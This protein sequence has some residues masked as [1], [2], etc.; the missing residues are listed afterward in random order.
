MF[1]MLI[2]K[3]SVFITYDTDDDIPSV[4]RYT[5]LS[6]IFRFIVPVLIIYK[7]IFMMF[8]CIYIYF[9]LSTFYFW[10]C[11]FIFCRKY[12][13]S[14]LHASGIVTSI[15]LPFFISPASFSKVPITK[16][17]R[18]GKFIRVSE[19]CPGGFNEL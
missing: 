7:L 16:H 13:N 17:F 5:S 3:C 6:I 10:N 4:L 18:F 2:H 14:R 12:Y 1:N 8:Y 9:S 11:F 19:N 15:N